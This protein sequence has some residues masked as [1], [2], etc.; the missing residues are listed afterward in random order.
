M[1]DY[2]VN[3]S[4]LYDVTPEEEWL[5]RKPIINILRVFGPLF[6]RHVLSERRKTL[7]NKG[8]PMVFLE[9]HSIYT[10]NY[11]TLLAKS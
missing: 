9:Y 10:Y 3:K 5:G 1:T 6:F 8:E 11:T 4:R 7:N 2:I